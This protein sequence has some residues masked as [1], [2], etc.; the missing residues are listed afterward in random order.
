MAQ[1]FHKYLKKGTELLNMPPVEIKSRSTDQTIVYNKNIKRL[2]YLAG[3]VYG[4]E[5]LSKVIMWAN[6]EYD[7]EYD[8]PDNTIIRIP[9][10]IDEVIN[11]IIDKIN[12]R[13]DVY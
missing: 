6:P 7:I 9:F 3:E 8:I 11:E 5:T 12:L 2:D 13:K 10:P 1:N 4:D